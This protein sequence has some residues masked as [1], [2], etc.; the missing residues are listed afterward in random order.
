MTEHVSLDVLYPSG[1][2]ELRI[3]RLA[4]GTAPRSIRHALDAFLRRLSVHDE[5]REDIVLA[6]GEALANAVEH[7]YTESHGAPE[8]DLIELYAIATPDGRR[9]SVEIRDCGRFIQR[10]PRSDRG[11]GF[12]IM[13]SIAREVA[14]DIDSGTRVR[15]LFE[16]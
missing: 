7:A 12:R 4:S 16:P 5:R 15:M 3:S 1:D 13:R 9:I 14:V 2:H 11:F 6:V 10:D 8:T